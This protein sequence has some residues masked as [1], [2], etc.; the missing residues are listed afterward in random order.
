MAKKLSKAKQKDLDLL[1]DLRLHVTDNT[2]TS[3]VIYGGGSNITLHAKNG[4][5][6]NEGLF[7][8]MIKAL[9]ESLNEKIEKLE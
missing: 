9:R 7:V 3:I 1:K 2:K 8:S 5:K 6:Q 4:A